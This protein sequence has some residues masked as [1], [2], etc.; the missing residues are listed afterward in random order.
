MKTGRSLIDL[1]R[2]LERQALTKRDFLVSTATTE[3]RLPTEEHPTA[4]SLR[5]T[6]GDAELQPVIQDLCHE[7]LGAHLVLRPGG[8]EG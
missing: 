6:V 8:C 7:Q 3:C 1:A 5:F 2:E 4:Y